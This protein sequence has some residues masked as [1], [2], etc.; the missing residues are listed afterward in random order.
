MARSLRA[1]MLP[2]VEEVARQLGFDPSPVFARF[3]IADQLLKTPEA[4]LSAEVGVELIETL[5]KETGRQDFG[6]RMA[7]AWR[8]STL[9]AVGLALFHQHS[10]RDVVATYCRFQNRLNDT[11]FFELEEDERTALLHAS[12]VTDSGVEATQVTEFSVAGMVQAFRLCLGRRWTPIEVHFTHKAPADDAFQRR[13]FGCPVEYASEFSG[14]LLSREDLDADIPSKSNDDLRAFAEQSAAA[15]PIVVDSM[16]TGQIKSRVVSLL[17]NGKVTLARVA[18]QL[19]DNE[20]SIQRRLA[21]EGTSFSDILDQVRVETVMKYIDNPDVNISDMSMMVGYED[22]GS[23][24]RW[25]A[26]RFGV[27]PSR[28][29]GRLEA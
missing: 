10:L 4:R 21:A 6:V 26:A 16:L 27:Q 3:H 9:G 8:L 2:L 14:V 17:S 18:S 15:L 29:R 5:A 25:F 20:R 1:R 13:F 11:V 24:S 7:Q 12:V 22:V 19:G 28:W 23:F